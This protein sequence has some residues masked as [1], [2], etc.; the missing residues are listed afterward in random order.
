VPT[1]YLLRSV[2]ASTEAPDDVR[3]R[4]PNYANVTW[5]TQHYRELSQL[6]SDYKSFI[7]WRH[8]PFQGE[9]INIG[10]SGN[11]WTLVGSIGPENVA[12]MHCGALG[13]DLPYPDRIYP[14]VRSPARRDGRKPAQ[15]DPF[16][17]VSA[18]HDVKLGGVP[19]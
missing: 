8:E 13:V 17:Q 11:H 9:T 18:G 4:L 3:A 7:G 10:F 16:I 1:W 14:I 5:A 6:K 2:L 15:S 19:R 12:T